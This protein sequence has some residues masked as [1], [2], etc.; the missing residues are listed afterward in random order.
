MLKELTEFSGI[1]DGRNLELIIAIIRQETAGINIKLLSVLLLIEA[2]IVF[3]GQFFLR[4]KKNISYKQC[5]LFYGFLVY[6][7]LLLMITIF[8][9]PEGSREGIVRLDIL[10]GFGLR[11]GYPSMWAATISL[12]NILL[13]IPLGIL[14]YTQFRNMK[15]VKALLTTTLIGGVV[16]L[17]VECTQLITGRGMFEVTDLLTNT[18]GSLLGAVFA[19]FVI[20]KK[21]S[22]K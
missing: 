10:L 16:S 12:L 2:V 7:D 18:F 1:M 20:N 22:M 8:R 6:M 3:G 4:K 13:F 19:A 5:L 9:R 14:L 21:R 11:T 17:M 15:R